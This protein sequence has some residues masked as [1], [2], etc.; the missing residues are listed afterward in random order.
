LLKNDGTLPVS[1]VKSVAVVG[2]LAD[3]GVDQVGT[4]C[5][6]AEPEHCITPLQAI[7]SL[8][9]KDFNIISEP[10][11]T[12]SRDTS[13][14]GIRRAVQAASQADIIL[15]FA[16]EEAVL[17]GEARCRA[18]ISLP[19]AQTEMLRALKSTGR[20]VVLILMAGRP[21]TIGA[22]ASMA[23]AVMYAFHGG[24][25]AGPA[26]ANLLFGKVVPS[27]KLPI[28][29]PKMVGQIP[30]YYAHPNTGRPAKNITYINEIPVGAKQESLGFTSYFLDAG[31]GPLYPFG[32]GLSYTSFA[33]S[34]PTLS[35]SDISMDDTLRVSCRVSNT[36][37]FDAK[38]VVQLYI[39][40]QYASVVRPVK[41][42]KGFQK[43]FLK[44]G[45]TK[46]VTFTLSTDNLAFT[47]NDMRRYAEPGEFQVWVAGD[48][49][50]GNARTF[51]LK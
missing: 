32:F 23:N 1:G 19:G 34:D 27:G 8:Y 48:S 31:D 5:F 42:L 50:G 2:P 35:A 11:L 26:L 43:I 40:D 41:E 30:V 15:Y 39:H 20:P 17:S 13:S 18:D 37:N 38:E 14:V 24:T 10:G 21:L 36:G 51:N 22:E 4:W 28:S 44:K 12:Y 6:D 7:R 9:G 46:T 47:H 25:M 33:Y 29:F 49:Q 3:R 16:G 45:E